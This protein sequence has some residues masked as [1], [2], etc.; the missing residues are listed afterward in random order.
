MGITSHFFKNKY[1]RNNLTE[2]LTW[3]TILFAVREWRCCFGDVFTTFQ[4]W[5]MGW[6]SYG[7][8]LTSN[9]FVHGVRWPCERIKSS[10][11]VLGEEIQWINLWNY[12]RLYIIYV[13]FKCFFM[14]CSTFCFGDIQGQSF[15]NLLYWLYYQRLNWSLLKRVTRTSC[16][17]TL[18]RW[19]LLQQGANSTAGGREAVAHR[20]WLVILKMILSDF[21]LFGGLSE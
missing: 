7:S 21:F 8:R 17:S 4:T 1:P 9:F 15:F 19:N 13:V 12:C 6:N 20:A 3:S 16:G 2:A 18:L 10:I 11:G 5:N 14:P